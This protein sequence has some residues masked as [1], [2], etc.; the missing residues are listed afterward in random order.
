MDPKENERSEIVW[1]G[2]AWD[3][4]VAGVCEHGNEPLCYVKVWNCLASQRYVTF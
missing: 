3:K 4:V 2:L 1:I